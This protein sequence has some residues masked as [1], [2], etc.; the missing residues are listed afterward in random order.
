M[1]EVLKNLFTKLDFIEN[2]GCHGN[3]MEFFK[4]FFKTLPLWKPWS[5]FEIISQECFLGDLFQ[6]LFS[7]FRSVYKNGSGE[8]GEGGLLAPYG[9]EEILK[10]SSSLKPLVRF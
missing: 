2:S 1:G 4:Q 8:W 9:H 10:K 3:E 7:K 6:K 5:N